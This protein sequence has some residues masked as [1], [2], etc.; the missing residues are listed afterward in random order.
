M[1]GR[2]TGGRL[3]RPGWERA[4][5]GVCSLLWPG[6]ERADDGVCYGWPAG[7]EQRAREDGAPRRHRRAAARGGEEDGRAA[8]RGGEGHDGARTRQRVVSCVE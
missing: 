2:V 1:A 4:D 7:R 5:D 8:A 6:W 3:L